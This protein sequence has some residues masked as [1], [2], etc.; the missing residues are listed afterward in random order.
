[1]LLGLTGAKVAGGGV[2]VGEA[3]E[4]G[5]CQV[6]EESLVQTSEP[7]FIP[8]LQE[9]SREPQYEIDLIRVLM[10]RLPGAGWRTDFRG[11]RHLP[12]MLIQVSDDAEGLGRGVWTDVSLLATFS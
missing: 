6:L 7:V 5:K 11:T 9:A 2:A 4:I 10:Q 1:M 12:V 3:E 8:S